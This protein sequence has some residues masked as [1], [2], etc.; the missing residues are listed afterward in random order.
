[1]QGSAAVSAAAKAIEILVENKLLLGSRPRR[2]S[3]IGFD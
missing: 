2:F 3:A 1:M